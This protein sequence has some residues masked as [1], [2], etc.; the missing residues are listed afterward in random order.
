LLTAVEE[1]LILG[2]FKI[3]INATNVFCHFTHKKKFLKI[4]CYRIVTYDIRITLTFDMSFAVGFNFSL[5][6]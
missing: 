2:Y 3:N 6:E 1:G 4:F 5:N